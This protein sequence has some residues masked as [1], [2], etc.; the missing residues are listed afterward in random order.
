MVHFHAPKFDSIPVNFL[1]KVDSA[2]KDGILLEAVQVL[3]DVN[4]SIK[5]AYIS[6][7]G[8]WFMDGELFSFFPKEEKIYILVNF[9][10][11]GILVINFLIRI[12]FSL[13]FVGFFSPARSLVTFHEFDFIEKLL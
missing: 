1:M 3:T 13:F 5:K 7:D 8:K 2:R 6:S 4:L 10:S 11:V 9:F 12:S